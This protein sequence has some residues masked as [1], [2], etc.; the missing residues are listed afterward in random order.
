MKT[1]TAW[2]ERWRGRIKA[3]VNDEKKRVNLVVCLGLAGLILLALPEWLPQEDAST[4]VEA[5]VSAPGPENYAVQLQEHLEQLIA[6][7]D[8]AGAARVMVTLASGEENIYATD[9]QTSADGQ[10]TVSHVL[11]DDDGLVETVQTPQVLGVAVVCEGG[12]DAAV[13]NQ[14]SELVEALTGV[15]ANHVTV[16]KMAAAE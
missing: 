4:R 11:L 14:I 9:R 7:V 3:L 12:G 1:G 8:G 10:D 13:Q 6:Q 2:L 5:E 16:A 15:G